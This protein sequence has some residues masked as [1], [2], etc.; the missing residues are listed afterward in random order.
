MSDNFV[1]APPSV[2]Q[3]SRMLAEQNKVSDAMLAKIQE[4]G[5]GEIAVPTNAY[6][7]PQTLDRIRVRHA[8]VSRAHTPTSLVP[9]VYPRVVLVDNIRGYL[10]VAR[11]L[12]PETYL[13]VG[14]GASSV[15]ISKRNVLSG[16][17]EVSRTL[18]VEANDAYFNSYN[19]IV[20]ETSY[21]GLKARLDRFFVKQFGFDLLENSS[22]A[23]I[24][25]SRAGITRYLE[26]P[27]DEPRLRSA[28]SVSRV[29]MWSPWSYTPGPNLQAFY[30]WYVRNTAVLG[31]DSLGLD[32]QGNFVGDPS[33]LDEPFLYGLIDHQRA[34]GHNYLGTLA[35]S[36]AKGRRAAQ[37]DREMY[38]VTKARLGLAAQL[39]SEAS[40]KQATD[41]ASAALSKGEV[42]PAKVP[43][44]VEAYLDY[45]KHRLDP[46]T[47]ILGSSETKVRD[48]LSKFMDSTA[49]APMVATDAVPA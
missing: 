36:A 13:V 1:W 12:P 20:Y 29:L 15:E 42:D 33:I 46:I 27:V 47:S 43:A 8:W 9:E 31:P 10:Q 38:G 25:E 45:P 22:T 26:V 24:V 35:T 48:L 40:R 16:L 23:R 2:D 4:A 7:Y 3:L 21:G 5:G 11:L 28:C 19:D 39:S 17:W 14:D 49:E 41:K 44:L 34:C 18:L 32:P 6:E 37:K 30:T